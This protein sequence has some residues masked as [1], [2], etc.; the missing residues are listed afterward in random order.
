MHG[1][2]VGGFLSFCDAT[3]GEQTYGDGCHFCDTMRG[4]DWGTTGT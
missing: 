1:L 3:Q 4:V 2:R